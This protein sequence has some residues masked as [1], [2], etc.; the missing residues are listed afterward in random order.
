[1]PVFPF[2]FSIKRTDKRRAERE[3][4]YALIHKSMT[5]LTR[6]PSAR[7]FSFSPRRLFCSEKRRSRLRAEFFSSSS[8]SSTFASFPDGDEHT[9]NDANA[10]FARETSSVP[11]EIGAKKNLAIIGGRGCGKSSVCRRLFAHEKR[12]KLLSLDDLIVYEESKSIPEIVAEHSW[13]YFR[14]VEFRCCEKAANAFQE[15]TLIDCGGGICVDLDEETGE[16]IYSERKVNALKETAMIVYIKR[17]VDYLASKIAGDANRPSLSE[18]NSFK[19]IME[20][21]GPW[22]ERAADLTLDGS[23]ESGSGGSNDNKNTNNETTALVKKKKIGKEILRYFYAKAGIEPLD[24]AGFYEIGGAGSVE[25]LRN[26]GK[27][28]WISEE[29]EIRM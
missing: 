23:L 16:E 26:A 18:T 11:I 13:R 7:R 12:F 22:Y 25:S 29:D 27:N 3:S 10:P 21:R 15:F 17:D 14:E 6:A 8:S 19:E 20:R 5:N 4:V 1:M 9:T 24:V 2:E 28:R